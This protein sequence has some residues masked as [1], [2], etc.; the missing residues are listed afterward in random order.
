MSS[1]H[2]SFYCF[3]LLK[4]TY[5]INT[6]KIKKIA[7]VYFEITDKPCVQEVHIFVVDISKLESCDQQVLMDGRF[8]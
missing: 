2:A 1:N 8:L 6:K 7:V 5:K 4:D 3:R